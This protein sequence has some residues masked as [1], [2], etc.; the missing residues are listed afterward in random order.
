MLGAA[1]GAVAPD[2]EVWEAALVEELFLAALV[3]EDEADD[4]VEV[5]EA[6]ALGPLEK[7]IL[8]SG[9]PWAG[10]I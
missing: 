4:A 7:A 10:W 8:G 5:A 3:A 2:E 9:L 6:P 1:D